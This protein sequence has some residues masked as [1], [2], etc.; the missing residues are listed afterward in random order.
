MD[1]VKRNELEH[2]LRETLKEH[3]RDGL[4][5]IGSVDQLVHRLSQAVE[6]WL[7][8]GHIAERKTA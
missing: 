8:S 4:N 1:D 7:E 6:Q 2:T 3:Q 5:M